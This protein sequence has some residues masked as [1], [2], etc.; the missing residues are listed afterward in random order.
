[1]DIAAEVDVACLEENCH[2]VDLIDQSAE[3]VIRYQ[4]VH[5]V[6]LSDVD[7][8]HQVDDQM[9]LIYHHV[10]LA[11][12]RVYYHNLVLETLDESLWQVF[13]HPDL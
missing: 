8:S 7:Q 1:V 6:D 4:K 3:C 9:A 5:R 13:P 10:F 11:W 2:R 12:V